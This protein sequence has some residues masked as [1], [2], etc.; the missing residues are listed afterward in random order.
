MSTFTAVYCLI[1][2]FC[3]FSF[4]FYK[5]SPYFMF[6]FCCFFTS[7]VLQSSELHGCMQTNDLAHLVVSSD[8]V[9]VF[10]LMSFGNLQTASWLSCT[11]SF[12]FL[13]L[14]YFL[15]FSLF[16]SFLSYFTLKC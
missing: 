10:I 9:T 7:T 8:A 14:K 13:L 16:L 15:K 11:K 5:M 12:T 2:D 1:I 6:C 3:L 4:L